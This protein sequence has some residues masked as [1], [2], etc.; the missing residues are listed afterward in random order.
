MLLRYFRVALLSL[1]A[2][3]V[4]YTTES[5]ISAQGTLELKG[6]KLD[7]LEV[8]GAAKLTDVVISKETEVN[9]SLRA[10]DCTFDDISIATD[11]L[12]LKHCSVSK[13][14]MRPSSGTLIQK[15]ILRQGSS[16]KGNIEFTTGTGEVYFYDSSIIE[17]NILNGK[18]MQ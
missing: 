16:V 8:N 11:I 14:I 5:F 17:G 13:I 6:I 7:N 10:N 18:R 3:N 1:T 15:V 9:G 2:M 4:L 12:E